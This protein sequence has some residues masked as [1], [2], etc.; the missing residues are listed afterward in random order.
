MGTTARLHILVFTP[1]KTGI[2]VISFRK[3]NAR[4]VKKYE[5]RKKHTTN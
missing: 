1:I 4:E 3:A 2:R 5:D